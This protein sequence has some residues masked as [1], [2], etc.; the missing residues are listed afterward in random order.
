M[1]AAP[2]STLINKWATPTESE[3]HYAIN[4]QAQYCLDR[5]LMIGHNAL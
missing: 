5:N 3:Y 1:W 2:Y 4:I